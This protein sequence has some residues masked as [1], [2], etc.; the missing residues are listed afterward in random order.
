MRVRQQKSERERRRDRAKMIKIEGRGVWGVGWRG[1][2]AIEASRQYERRRREGYFLVM[3][4]ASG[5][6]PGECTHTRT[7]KQTRG[8]CRHACQ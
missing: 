8:R 4:F 5:R 6:P 1:E 2:S 3:P 7:H